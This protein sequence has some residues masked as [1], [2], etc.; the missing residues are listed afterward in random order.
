MSSRLLCC[1]GLVLCCFVSA[2][3]ALADYPIEVIE[4]KARTLDEVL[5]V[6]RPLVGDDAAVTGMGNNLIIKASPA[7]VAAVRKLL[8]EIDRPPK[9]L[10]IT[11][12]N[13][14][15]NLGS[16]SGYA[17][18]A[19]I[20]T[21]Q[22]QVG[23]NS[24]GR[25]VEDSQGR[26]ALHD[27]DTRRSRTASQQ[28]QALEGRPAYISAGAQVPVRERQEFS[29]N[30]APYRREV[31]GL[32]DVSSGFYVVP[33]VSGE[34]VSLEILQHDDRRAGAGGRI[35]TQRATTTVRARLGEWVDLGGIDTRGSGSRAGL[36][37]AMRNQESTTQQIRV[38]V[39][40]LDCS[41]H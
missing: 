37:Y 36:G 29:V 19:D 39:E 4:L 27:A 10:L 9:R 34:F 30:G 35:D 11:V 31:T 21:G 28:V 25:P 15:E 3:G 12:S 2:R 13:Q 24:P 32:R 20:K 14:G 17:A 40:C 22:G 18:S 8:A 7:Q 41:S 16:T 1:L 26:I 33:R 23:I 38:K 5:P 6:V